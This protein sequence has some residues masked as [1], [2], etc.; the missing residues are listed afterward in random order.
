M[1]E[2]DPEVT[3]ALLIAV[4]EQLQRHGILANHIVV[5]VE[6]IEADGQVALW[7]VA[8]EEVSGWQSLGMLEWAAARERAGATRDD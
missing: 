3:D 2:A 8:N 6:T 5:L 1:S 4:R 7:A